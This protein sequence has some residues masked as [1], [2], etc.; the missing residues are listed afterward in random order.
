[1]TINGKN[2]TDPMDIHKRRAGGKIFISRKLLT[3]G[4]NVVKLSFEN[5]YYHDYVGI[6]STVDSEGNQFVFS[7]TVPYWANRILPLFDQP[8]IKGT[9][10]IVII[11][12]FFDFQPA[13]P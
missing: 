2:I 7:Q 1:M 9:H 10:E 3:L 6:H 4:P 13:S 8:D 5:N 12:N 11:G